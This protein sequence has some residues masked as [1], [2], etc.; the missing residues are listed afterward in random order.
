MRKR[1]SSKGTKRSKKSIVLEYLQ[2]EN[3]ASVGSEH[4]AAIRRAL[5]QR[6]GARGRVSGRYLL[7]IVESAGI[8]AAAEIGGLP[9]DLLELLKFDTL[10]GAEQALE[11]LEAQRQ[12]GRVEECRRAARRARDDAR[13]IA[14]NPRVREVVRAEHTEIA[15]WFGVWIETPEIFASWLE[16]RKN[17]AE[18]KARF[19][20]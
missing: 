3:P 1:T 12:A 13:L 10:L 5:H 19:L 9:A 8:A 6:L 17:S 15:L 11:S 4:V 7:N 18:F 2:R 20:V 14:R 16:I